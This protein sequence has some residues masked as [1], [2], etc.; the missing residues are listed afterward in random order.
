MRVV[1]EWLGID[2]V[3]E[4]DKDSN[5]Y[6]SFAANHDA[7]AAESVSFI[8]EVLTNGA[9]TLQEL[10]GAEW[11]II[12][13]TNGATDDEISAYYTGYYGLDVDGTARDDDRGSS[14]ATG[15][16]RVGILNQGAFLS[17]FAT[18]TG[19]HPVLRGVAVMRRVACLDLPDPAELDITVVPPVP[20][21]N[22]PEDHAR[23][24][25]PRTPPTR[26]AGR[27]H[28]PSTTS[29][30]RSSS[31]TAWAPSAARRPSGRPRAP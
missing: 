11:T 29:A 18:A 5:V 2:G 27:C 30:S 22:T 25:T 9:G 21:P 8:D 6:P 17:R 26:S 15:G 1:R 31:T 20:D 19:S 28:Q 4:I 10:L 24:S 12:D 13:S 7:M 16:T 14:G 3:D 23:S